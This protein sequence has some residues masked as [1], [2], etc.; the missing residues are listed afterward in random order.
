MHL[1]IFSSNKGFVVQ[2]LFRL[3]GILGLDITLLKTIAPDVGQQENA[4]NELK[5]K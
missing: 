5:K 4:K 1:V 2:L 3:L